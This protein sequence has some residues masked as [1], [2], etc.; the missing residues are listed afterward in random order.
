MADVEPYGR[1]HQWT[2]PGDAPLVLLQANL[3]QEGTSAVLPAS[4]K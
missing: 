2:N 1:V 4:T 3:S